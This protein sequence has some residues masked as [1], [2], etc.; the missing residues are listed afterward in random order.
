MTALVLT[1][2]NL[3]LVKDAL[4]AQFPAIKSAHLTEALAYSVNH[5]THAS[6]LAALDAADPTWPDVVLLNKTR[7]LDRA[8]ELGYSLRNASNS[9]RLF[10]RIGIPLFENSGRGGGDT[11]SI[12]T[13]AI[14]LKTDS[15][16]RDGKKISL[17]STRTRAWTNMMVAAVNAGIDQKL[18]HVL[19]GTNRWPGHSN[20]DGCAYEFT[21]AENVPALA[22]VRSISWDELSIHVALWPTPKAIEW[23]DAGNAGFLVGDA[24]AAGWLER[25]AG[26]YLQT[27]TF[28]RCRKNKL[29]TVADTTIVPKGFGDRGRL[30]L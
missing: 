21:F 22:H 8:E 5:R 18:F 28:F 12:P 26:S 27:S 17:S 10:D 1:R 30:H 3:A 15:V 25:R 29:A 24:W 20:D 14:L 19:P 13:N 7:F 11:A 2:A 4:R 16:A 6:L 9:K 23:M